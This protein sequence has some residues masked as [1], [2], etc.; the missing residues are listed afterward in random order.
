[1][2]C[3]RSSWPAHGSRWR[4]RHGWRA[5]LWR[6]GSACSG[7]EDWKRGR[8][9]C[10]KGATRSI[11]LGCDFRLTR[12]SWIGPGG[13][14]RCGPGWFLGEWCYRCLGPVGSWNWPPGRSKH[15]GYN[16]G[17]GS[18]LERRATVDTPTLHRVYLRYREVLDNRTVG[19]RLPSERA[20]PRHKAWRARRVLWR[21]S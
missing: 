8:R 19:V 3:F 21:V 10:L 6:G 14:W 4:A 16:R 15:R 9:W 11:R 1:M 20:N 7:G 17:I 12:C 5:V 18:T 2:R 13:W